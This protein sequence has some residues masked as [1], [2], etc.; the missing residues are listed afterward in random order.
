MFKLN[1]NFTQTFHDLLLGILAVFVFVGFSG[2]TMAQLKLNLDLDLEINQAPEGLPIFPI[3]RAAGG[4]RMQILP[5]PIA[6][7]APSTKGISLPAQKKASPEELDQLAIDLAAVSFNVRKAASQRLKTLTTQDMGKLTTALMDTPS[8]EA[9]IRVHAE[10]EMRYQAESKADQLQASRLLEMKAQENR[11]ISADPANH[12]L[13]KHW[14]TRVEVAFSELEAMGAIVKNGHFSSPQAGAGLLDSKPAIQVLMT[15]AWSG[16]DKGLEV[17]R[18]LKLLTGPITPELNGLGVYLLT[19]HSLSSEQESRLIDIVG[20]NR[21][22]HR[23]VVALGITYSPMTQ[24]QFEGVLIRG[25]SKGGSADKAGLEPGDFLLAMYPPGEKVIPMKYDPD[26]WRTFRR[27][28][29]AL[30]EGMKPDEVD[31][32]DIGSNPNRLTD[33]QQLVDRLKLYQPGDKVK[34]QVVK[35]FSMFQTWRPLPKLDDLGEGE[36]NQAEMAKVIEVDVELIGWADL[37]MVQ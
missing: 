18:R 25:V 20:S 23:S 14:K 12:S 1:F 35:N 36:E 9:L 37:P 3:Q 17:F 32:A 34:L 15:K 22:Q 11:L 2:A 30:P 26:S 13:T 24:G 28:V 5:G 21:I 6:S 10:L 4:Q 29:P 16:G 19:G 7:E 8:A 33:F 27:P 31:G